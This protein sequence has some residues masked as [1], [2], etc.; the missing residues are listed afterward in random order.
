MQSF[1]RGTMSRC[2]PVWRW[3]FHECG[4][5][6]RSFVVL[7]LIHLV[8]E[9]GLCSENRLSSAV[10]ATRLRI[11]P[12]S[13]LYSNIQRQSRASSPWQQHAKTSRGTVYKSAPLV[14]QLP[15]VHNIRIINSAFRNSLFS[16]PCQEFERSVNFR[17]KLYCSS[18]CYQ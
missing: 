18:L 3:Q 4:P 8:K 17:M 2:D 10:L 5:S 14:I 11:P 6:S 1:D 12:F 7:V 15:K 16:P 9:T 13:R